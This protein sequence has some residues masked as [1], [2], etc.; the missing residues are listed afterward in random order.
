MQ[1]SKKLS[2]EGDVTVLRGLKLE[3][4]MVCVWRGKL[5]MSCSF[6]LGLLEDQALG[7]GKPEIDSPY[8]DQNDLSILCLPGK[9]KKF[10]VE[11]YTDEISHT[12]KY[13]IIRHIRK[14]DQRTE[15]KTK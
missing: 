3:F 4:R 8:L 6:H 5:V 15:S 14:Q 13:E 7:Q 2:R 9:K 1:K 12:L 11:L 10:S